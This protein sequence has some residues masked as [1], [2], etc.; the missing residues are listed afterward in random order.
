MFFETRYQ[1]KD[2]FIQGYVA[3]VKFT[4][5]TVI[6]IYTVLSEQYFLQ[7]YIYNKKLINKKIEE[8]KKIKEINKV[9]DKQIIKRQKRNINYTIITSYMHLWAVDL[10]LDENN[11]CIF[12]N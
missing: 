1:S 4:T 7:K 3:H 12:L 5:I 9:N 6:I 2:V 10:H 8:K 11:I